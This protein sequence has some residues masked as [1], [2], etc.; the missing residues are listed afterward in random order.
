MVKHGGATLYT[1]FAP[2]KNTA[3]VI[4]R[5]LNFNSSIT[6]EANDAIRALYN[7]FLPDKSFNSVPERLWKELRY[8][9]EV[10]KSIFANQPTLT[11]D[12]QQS[13]INLTAAI[14]NFMDKLCNSL[15]KINLNNACDSTDTC[16]NSKLQY[17][18]KEITDILNNIDLE[19]RTLEKLQNAKQGQ[20]EESMIKIDNFDNKDGGKR[21]RKK[22]TRRHTNRRKR[23]HRHY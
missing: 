20:T 2:L 3:R 11:S 7:K 10:R 15:Q 6:V 1:G 13:I 23:S 5:N 19:Y 14:S 22:Q 18:Y 21:H 4:S 16:R 12:N 17:Y 9:T 8:L